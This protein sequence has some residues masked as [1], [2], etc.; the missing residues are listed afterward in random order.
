MQLRVDGSPTARSYL[1]FNV[2]GLVDPVANATLYVYA[3]SG[4]SS[5]YQVGGVS[6][7]N[8]TETGLTYNNAP[9]V[10]AAGGQFR[11][12][13]VEHLDQVDVTALVGGNGTVNLAMGGTSDTAISFSSREGRKSTAVG[14]HD[15]RT[16]SRRQAAA[17]ADAIGG[18]DGVRALVD[19]DGDGLT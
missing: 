18:L 9:A 1:R 11:G 12:C 3:N 5:G 2:Q 8:W 14:G 16:G 10:G 19:S 4:S 17:P 13:C 7:N 6:D 15:R